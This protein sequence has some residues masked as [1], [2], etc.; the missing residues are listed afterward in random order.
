MI[1]NHN[2]LL[3]PDIQHRIDSARQETRTLYYELESVRCRIQD[4]TLFEVAAGVEHLSGDHFNLRLY[5]TLRG[6]QNKIAQIRWNANLRHILSASQDGY[7]IIWDTVS[8][9]KK[10]AISLEN[11][12]V[13]AC[14]IAP[15]GESVASGGLDNTLTVYN[16]KPRNYQY[17]TQEQYQTS[18]RSIFKGHKA[19][20]S[21]CD[22]IANDKL[23]TASGDMT[24]SM[25]DMAKGSKVRDYVD[26]IGDVLVLSRFSNSYGNDSSPLFISGSSD[27]YAKIWDSRCQFAV[28]NYPVSNSDVN[29]IK[30]FPDNQSFVT[31]SDD[32]IIRFF[33]LRADCELC[34]YSLSANLHKLDLNAQAPPPPSS[35]LHA[36]TPTDQISRS[37]STNSSYDTPGVVSLDFSKSGRL[38]YS[39]YSD[40]GCIIWD[41]LKGEIVGALGMAGHLNKVNQVSSSPDGLII[42]TASWDQTIKVW[43]V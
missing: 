25:W 4:T 20:I 40:Y 39:C 13:L 1:K 26:H 8:G 2:G 15:N 12:W 29:S 30:V 21:D 17:G 9:F 23:I 6:H 27:G 28:Q 5:N 36:V 16:I 7:M 35:G 11:Q 31:G 43:S 14:A 42:C 41:T 19:Y 34:N 18:I 33:D 37:E 3:R 22:Y 38:L 24:C 32:G 10:H